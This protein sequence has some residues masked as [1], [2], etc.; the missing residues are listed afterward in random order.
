[1]LGYDDYLMSVGKNL[2]IKS[3]GKYAS[4]SDAEY[5]AAMKA[6]KIKRDQTDLLLD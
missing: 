2:V 4:L 3:D 1:M 6:G 5:A